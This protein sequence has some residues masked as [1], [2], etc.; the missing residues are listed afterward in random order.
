MSDITKG[1]WDYDMGDMSI[2][3]LDESGGAIPLYQIHD[4]GAEGMTTEDERE[5][6]SRL[7][8]ASKDL[9]EN[10]KRMTD[11]FGTWVK[12]HGHEATAETWAALHCEEQ[13]IRKAEGQ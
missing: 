2:Y 7:V 9:L 13:D 3:A 5:A 1:P 6:N 11:H 4:D 12:D 8:A 10:L